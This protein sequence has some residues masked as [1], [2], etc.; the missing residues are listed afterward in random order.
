MEGLY[1]PKT[2][3]TYDATIVLDDSGGQYVNFNLEFQQKKSNKEV[4]P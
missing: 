3:K 1:S 2:G 4:E